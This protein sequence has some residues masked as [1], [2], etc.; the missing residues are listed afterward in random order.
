MGPFIPP[1]AEKLCIIGSN[2]QG[3]PVHLSSQI[4]DLELPV[5]HEVSGMIRCPPGSS[6]GL[7]DFFVVAPSGD[8]VILDSGKAP[9]AVDEI[10]LDILIIQIK[11]DVPVKVPVNIVP[12]ITLPGTPDLFEG[13]PVP[14]EGRQ[15][16]RRVNR[17][18]DGIAGTGFGMQYSVG[19]QDY[20]LDAVLGEDSINARDKTAFRQPKPFRVVSEEVPVCLNT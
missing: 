1:V 4:L 6:L 2:H 16:C 17:C 18:K 7:V 15:P 11:A 8:P 14:A 5:K 10:G 12:R 13:L 20:L 9:D 19:V 3:L